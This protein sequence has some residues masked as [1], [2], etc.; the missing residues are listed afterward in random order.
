MVNAE[1]R[2]RCAFV[3]DPELVP[4]RP[5]PH[6]PVQG[7]RYFEPSEIP[8]D[9]AADDAEAGDLPPEMAAE[10]RELGLL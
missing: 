6:R 4:T 3:L 8:P 1:G 5:Q 7:W 9:R 2:S 10:L